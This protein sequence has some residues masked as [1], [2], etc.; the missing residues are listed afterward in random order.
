MPVWEIQVHKTAIWSGTSRRYVSAKNDEG[1][2]DMPNVFGITDD[3]L[4][5][6]YEDDGRDND[7]MMQRLLQRCKEVNPLIIKRTQSFPGCY[8]LSR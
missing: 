6:G 1:F 5:V 8:Y 3:I 4:V 2:N 7:K